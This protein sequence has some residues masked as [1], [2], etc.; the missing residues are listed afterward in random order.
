MN[1]LCTE[2]HQKQIRGV[3]LTKSFSKGRLMLAYGA[4][5]RPDWGPAETYIHTS[6]LRSTICKWL[7]RISVAKR[8]VA[9]VLHPCC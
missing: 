7:A 4:I 3:L 9:L 1:S 6:C 8:V 5:T 2:T